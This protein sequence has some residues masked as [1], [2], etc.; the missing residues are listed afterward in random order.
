M[1]YLY[2]FAGGGVLPSTTNCYRP[3]E[4]PAVLATLQFVVTD[5]VETG[6]EF[7]SVDFYWCDCKDN[8][9]WSPTHEELYMASIVMTPEG[10]RIKPIMMPGP[11]GASDECFLYDFN[12]I[13]RVRRVWF[14]NGGA[15]IT[16][17]PQPAP[18]SVR[19]PVLILTER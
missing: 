9:L 16:P 4:L 19:I 18:Y 14:R 12:Y 8:C 5:R 6:R 11:S 15:D 10:Q 17:A 2:A 13:E 3:R 1:L 7:A